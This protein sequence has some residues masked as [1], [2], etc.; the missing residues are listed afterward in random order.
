MLMT[1]M[2]GM[3]WRGVVRTTFSGLLNPLTMHLVGRIRSTSSRLPSLE[4]QSADHLKRAA[5][6]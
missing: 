6:Q 3:L 1:Q 4:S 2:R 5:G